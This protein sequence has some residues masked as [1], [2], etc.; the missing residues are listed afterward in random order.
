[1][2][3]RSEPTSVVSLTTPLKSCAVAG[4]RSAL[5]IPS[6]GTTTLRATRYSKGSFFCHKSYIRC[7]FLPVWSKVLQGIHFI[8]FIGAVEPEQL[9]ALHSWGETAEV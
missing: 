4:C 8:S 1:M 3:F 5:S 9:K 6:V 7:H 2:C